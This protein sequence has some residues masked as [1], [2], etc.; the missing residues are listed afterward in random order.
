MMFKNLLLLVCL[1][2]TAQQ[3]DDY[4]DVE[5]T[6]GPPTETTPTTT[7]ATTTGTPTE[8]TPTTTMMTTTTLTTPTTTT[9]STIVPTTTMS[10][11]TTTTSTSLPTTT[12][13][14]P[15]ENVCIC[16]ER[17]K[18]NVR[19]EPTLY[20]LLQDITDHEFQKLNKK[21]DF[22]ISRT[23]NLQPTATA[24]TTT[25][26]TTTTTTPTTKKVEERFFE[27]VFDEFEESIQT[28]ITEKKAKKE[29]T[30]KKNFETLLI[31]SLTSA[32][33]ATTILLMVTLFICL[34]KK[35]QIVEKDE[36]KEGGEPAYEELRPRVNPTIAQPEDIPFID[37]DGD[38]SNMETENPVNILKI[39]SG[40]IRK[41][42]KGFMESSM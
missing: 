36:E 18:A 10:L 7:D 21:I 29:R 1:S 20:S 40:F 2:A 31:I 34:K 6:T 9:N 30:E 17:E 42:E 23:S 3:F 15:S 16:G 25:S 12:T 39:K 38:E 13:S 22:L 33:C 27:D 32:G 24:S 4:F 37:E 26:T 14:E 11:P 5:L 19:L 41:S 35:P 28:I 8:T